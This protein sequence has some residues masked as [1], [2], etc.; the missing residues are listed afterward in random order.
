VNVRRAVRFV[1][2]TAIVMLSC[3]VG[4]AALATTKLRPPVITEHFT[5]LPCNKNTTLGMEGC[6]ELQLL[7][8]DRR[9]NEEVA[10]VFELY[11]TNGQ[12]LDFVKAEKLWF[13]Y[14]GSDCQSFAA[15]FGGGSIAPV[16][17]AECEVHD[18]QLRSTDL[19]SFYDELTQDDNTNLPT[20]P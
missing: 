14:R 19:H 13:T 6:A 4:N 7:S 1:A 5:R 11:R 12:K 8:A 16:D 20:W 18:N 2:A 15:I 17:Y 3:L 9:L 10:I